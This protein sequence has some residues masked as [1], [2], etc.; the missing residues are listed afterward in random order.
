[1][2]K[3][4]KIRIYPN[5]EQKGL[6]AVWMDGSRWMYNEAVSLYRLGFVVSEYELRRVVLSVLPKR[7]ANVPSKILYGAVADAYKSNQA[8]WR[9]RK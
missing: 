3:S 9:K 7:F 5:A 1:M 2:T 4:R 6:L 8:V